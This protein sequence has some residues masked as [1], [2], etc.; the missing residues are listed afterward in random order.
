LRA[1]FLSLGIRMSLLGYLGFQKSDDL[2]RSLLI[3]TRG[4]IDVAM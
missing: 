4:S 2:P 1:G 3:F